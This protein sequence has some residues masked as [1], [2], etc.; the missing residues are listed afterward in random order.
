M[1]LSDLLI[2]A[3]DKKASDLHL[4]SG[5]AAMLRIDG[6]LQ[7]MDV[8]IFSHSEITQMLYSIMTEEQHQH[9]EACIEMDFSFTL[10]HVA[11]FRVHIFKQS[12]GA[13]AV[14]RVIPSTLL[15]NEQLGLPKIIKEITTIPNGLVLVTG[16]TGSGKSTTLA[17]MI[18]HINATRYQHIVSIEDPIE[19]VHTNKQCLIHQRE[20]HRDT[21]SFNAA[22][23][24]ALRE[25]PDVIVLGE[26][27]DLETIRLAITAAET[28]H[29]VLASLHT[30]SAS[31]TIHRMIDVF[32]AEEKAMICSILSESLQAIV[33]QKLL[34]K[35]DGGRVAAFEILMCTSAIRHLIRDNKIAQIYSFMQTGQSHGMHTLDQHLMELL[36]HQIITKQTALENAVNQT[37]FI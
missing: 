23:R 5:V 32:P 21:L 33:A 17:A 34:K 36:N 11:R 18:E 31:K 13:S 26:L 6:D 9:Y 29:L 20:V 27:R 10:P 24:A 7:K 28:G 14:F 19:F 35:I 1:D 15:S 22:I 37:L 3:M 8:P 30:H 16:P 12:R 4:S 2:M 25:D